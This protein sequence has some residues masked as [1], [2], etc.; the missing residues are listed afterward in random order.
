MPVPGVSIRAAT[1]ADA[2]PIREFDRT[3]CVDDLGLERTFHVVATEP[4][5]GAVGGWGVAGPDAATAPGSFTLRLS[6]RPDRLGRGV[7]GTLLD[8]LLDHLRSSGATVV[9]VWLRELDEGV[10]RFYLR[11]GFVEYRRTCRLLLSPLAADLGAFEPLFEGVKQQGVEIVSFDTELGRGFDALGAWHRL[12]RAEERPSETYVQFLERA[13]QRWTI[14][15]TLHFAKMGDAYVGY[16]SLALPYLD[17]GAE[18]DPGLVEQ[19]YVRVSEPFRNRGIATALCAR[20]V[21]VARWRGYHTI[22]SDVAQANAASLAVHARLGYVEA[23][24][25]VWV[26]KSPV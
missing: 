10:L 6:V 1:A 18:G 12:V 5:T 2:E 8:R 13:A 22:R 3:F 4:G 9:H 21:E 17:P 7:G 24:G 14:G 11:R 20:M 15:G 26:R 23:G 25:E 19:G 16:T